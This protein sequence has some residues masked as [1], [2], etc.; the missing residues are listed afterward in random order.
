MK[1]HSC[2]SVYHEVTQLVQRSGVG[3]GLG[4]RICNAVRGGVWDVVWVLRKGLMVVTHEHAQTLTLP[5]TPPLTLTLTK[6]LTPILTLTL[7]LIGLMTVAHE[8]A[9]SKRT[10]A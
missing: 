1:S 7:T 3:L 8:H 5:L 4:R 9:Q 2:R 10:Q 6:P